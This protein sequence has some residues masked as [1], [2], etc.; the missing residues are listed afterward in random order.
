MPEVLECTISSVVFS[1]ER[2][3]FS[4]VRIKYGKHSETAAGN[5]PP[6]HAGERVNLTGDWAEHPKF[7]KQ[8]S[9][10]N[11]EV[12]Q[13]KGESGLI[14]YLASGIFAGIGEKTA[15]KL[16]AIFGE[17]L[18]SVLDRDPDRLKGAVRGLSGK[19]LEKFIDD[20][21]LQQESRRALLFLYKLGFTGAK[22]MLVWNLY[23]TETESIVNENPYALC[24]E[25]FA[26]PF[27]IA[28]NAAKKLGFDETAGLRLRASVL[29]VLREAKYDGG[30]AFM[31]TENLLQNSLNFLRIIPTFPDDDIY[32]YLYSA[33]ADLKKAKKVIIQGERVWLPEL[34]EAE[35][36]IGMFV[37]R[38]LNL[39]FL[40]SSHSDAEINT[41]ASSLEISYSDEQLKA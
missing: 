11:C 29:H 4:V 14:A 15:E 10:V 16:V 34:Y 35:Q 6:I 2:N 37:R 19:R 39:D 36:Y 18:P 25:P 41:A 1:N 40:E 9:V 12:L 21:S 33:L 30:H 24:E 13:P 22:T 20:W 38:A 28:D 8:F 3:G 23:K 5:F 17:D 31:P 26:Y 7:G 32:D 27:E